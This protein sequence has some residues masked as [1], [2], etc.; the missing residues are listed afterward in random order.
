MR[1]Y[2]IHGRLTKQSGRAAV[3]ISAAL[4]GVSNESNMS[5]RPLMTLR[6]F[7]RSPA[8]GAPLFNISL[9]NLTDVQTH[10]YS[11]L[12]TDFSRQTSLWTLIKVFF[13]I[14]ESLVFWP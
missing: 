14:D 1:R 4:S 7:K 6:L 11:T 10:T 5:S 3:G 2:C 12:A 8:N 9:A 13:Y